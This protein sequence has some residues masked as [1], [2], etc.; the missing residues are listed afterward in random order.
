MHTSFAFYQYF[1]FFNFHFIAFKLFKHDQGSCF[2]KTQNK[3]PKIECKEYAKSGVCTK[4]N[5]KK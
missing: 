3:Y 1:I 2:Q 4:K 5:N